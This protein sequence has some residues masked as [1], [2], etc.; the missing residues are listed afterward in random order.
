MLNGIS[1]QETAVPGPLYK[2]GNREE[3]NLQGRKS[4]HFLQI[5]SNVSLTAEPRVPEEN[6][7]LHEAEPQFFSLVCTRVSINMF[8]RVRPGVKRNLLEGPKVSQSKKTQK[9]PQID[10]NSLN[11]SQ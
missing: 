8:V 9:I 3:R 5:S 1:S 11:M 6:E 7:L 2:F 4:N 10:T